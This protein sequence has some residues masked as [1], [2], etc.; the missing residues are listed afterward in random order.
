MFSPPASDATW[1]DRA[2]ER[3]LG[4][5]KARSADRLERLL[6]AALANETG[7]AAFT[8]QQLCA[9]AGFSL[10]GFYSS[11]ASK[12][13]AL[14][15]LLEED[16]GI[17]A[18]LLSQTIDAH[19]E[20]EAR[21]HAYIEAIFEMLTYPGAAG[22]ASVL[23][24]EYRRLRDE[25][26]DELR[27]ALAPLLDLLTSEIAGATAARDIASADPV[28]DAETVFALLLDGI[29]DVTV[30]RADPRERAAYL[31]RFCRDGLRG[32]TD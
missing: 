17:G 13:E 14:L 25:R 9:R 10:K 32:A 22:Y 4:G 19:T 2:L 27:R 7:S 5:A 12:D 15:A 30:G 21:L 26:P 6:D 1:R 29:G 18:V 3:S 20:P 31:W 28:R 11:F 8:V 23:V 16:S 24:R